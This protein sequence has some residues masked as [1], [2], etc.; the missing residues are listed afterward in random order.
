[1]DAACPCPHA[2]AADLQNKSSLPA[3]RRRDAPLGRLMHETFHRNV[4]TNAGG[5]GVRRPYGAHGWAQALRPYSDTPV[6]GAP[7]QAPTG[8]T[9]WAGQRPA[10]T[11]ATVAALSER[12]TPLLESTRRSGKQCLPSTALTAARRGAFGAEDSAATGSGR[13]RAEAR[14]YSYPT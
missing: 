6:P 2:S 12:R 9:C 14:R 3:T 7:G 10:P 1:M 8:A 5:R 13:C 4:S 11:N